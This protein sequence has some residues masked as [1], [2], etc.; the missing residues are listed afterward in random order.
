MGEKDG[1]A[2][3]GAAPAARLWRCSAASAVG[4]HPPHVA[5]SLTGSHFLSLPD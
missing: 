5:V 2:A 3:K 1:A 4:D